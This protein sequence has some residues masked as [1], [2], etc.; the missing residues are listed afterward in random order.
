[1]NP[2]KYLSIEFTHLIQN[3]MYLP[4]LVRQRYMN[5]PIHQMIG[6]IREKYITNHIIV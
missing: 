3:S 5:N 4:K 1:M 6:Y 2:I